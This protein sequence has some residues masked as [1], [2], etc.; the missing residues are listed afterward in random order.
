MMQHNDMWLQE[1]RTWGA[2]EHAVAANTATVT[3]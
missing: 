3:T 2:Q 1:T